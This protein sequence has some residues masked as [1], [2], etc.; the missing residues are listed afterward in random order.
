MT[1]APA[2]ARESS[3]AAAPVDVDPASAALKE[4][5]KSLKGSAPRGSMAN[6]TAWLSARIAEMEKGEFVVS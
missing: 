4:T 5:Y 2:D 3:G 6:N 1:N